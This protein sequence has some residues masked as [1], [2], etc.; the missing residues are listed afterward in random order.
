METF[1][2]S[3]PFPDFN[4][5]CSLLLQTPAGIV[6]GGAQRVAG[7]STAAPKR[8][9]LAALIVWFRDFL[10]IVEDDAVG[11]GGCDAG[12]A[13]GSPPSR[14]LRVID[15]RVGCALEAVQLVSARDDTLAVELSLFFLPFVASTSRSIN[16]GPFDWLR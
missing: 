10:R 5:V 16:F 15:Q 6:G 3:N 7:T 12:G 8:L 4:L 13:W 11:G 14:L 9:P 2:G 1:T